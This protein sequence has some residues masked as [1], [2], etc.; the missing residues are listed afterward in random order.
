LYFNGFYDPNRI[1][2]S[3][4]GHH[5]PSF[6][7]FRLAGA[8]ISGTPSFTPG[9][10]VG[11]YVWAN[12]FAIWQLRASTPPA[13]GNAFA[14]RTRMVNGQI[15]AVSPVTL[16]PMTHGERGTR[17]YRNDG[18]VF[19]DVTA[20]SAVTD[21]VN[22][23]QVAWADVDADGF[24]DLYVLNKGD[25]KLFNQPN[26]LYRSLGNG[27]F[28]D[29]TAAF[30]LAGDTAG[31]ADACAF[32]DYDDDGDQDVAN[33]SGTGPRNVA[34][35]AKHRHYRNDGPVGNHLRV[36]LVGGEW[37]TRDAYGSWVTCVS[38][39]AGRQ[40][41]YVTGNAWRGA[42]TM[43]D[44][45]FGLGSDTSVDTLLVQWPTGA[46][47]VLTDVPAGTVTV[48]EPSPVFAPEVHEGRAA[49]A[50][51][52]G[53]NPTRRSTRFAFAGRTEDRLT[54]E[55]F[56]A[57]GRSIRREAVGPAATAFLWD[58]VDA[59]GLRVAAGVYFV[60]AREGDRTAEAKVVLLR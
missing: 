30:G 46:T 5:P 4:D 10:S 44:P 41:H 13:A 43:I 23:R 20:A 55:I 19:T 42:N 1:F 60:R 9:Q 54:I 40:S 25:T 14:G 52:V 59:R 33:L 17:I 8:E 11:F 56:D 45:Y 48:P 26:V 39:A 50:L 36:D 7:P 58:G 57:S 47:S 35:T 21:T 22:V 15:T 12:S 53:P 6:T 32:E 34:T 24:L 51:A 3:G 49:L 28:E 2:I 29:A 27:T 18:S 16:E 38:Q 31:M 37:S